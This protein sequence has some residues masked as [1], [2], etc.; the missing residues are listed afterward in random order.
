MNKCE[1]Q[2][3]IKPFTNLKNENRELYFLRKNNGYYFTLLK[4]TQTKG[5]T[6]KDK[7]VFMSI[8]A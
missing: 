6:L 4:V 7:E 8:I 1:Y 5:R 3:D 2:F